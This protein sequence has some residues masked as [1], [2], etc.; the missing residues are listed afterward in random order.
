M[1][2]A[3]TQIVA[4]ALARVGIEADGLAG[5]I[6]EDFG[7]RRRSVMRLFPDTIPTLEALRARGVPLALVTNGDKREQRDKIERHGLAPYFDAIVIE[8]ELGAGK[9]EPAVYHH[10]LDALGVTAEGAWMAGDHLEFDVGAPQRLG[11][12]GAWIDRAARGLPSGSAVNPECVLAGVA[13][14]VEIVA[15]LAEVSG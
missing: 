4:H 3:W 13:A 1:V 11:L 5:R 7:A 12:R 9:P 6:A 2:G 8:G 15:P 10:A 14:L